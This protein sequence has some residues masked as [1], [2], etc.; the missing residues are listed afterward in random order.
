MY[1]KLRE[2]TYTLTR[3]AGK[4]HPHIRMMQLQLQRAI[5]KYIPMSVYTSRYTWSLTHLSL[6]G[7]SFTAVS[8]KNVDYLRNYARV[9]TDS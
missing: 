4:K 9:G 1:P 5:H 8:A 3:S 7:D 2:A 6:T